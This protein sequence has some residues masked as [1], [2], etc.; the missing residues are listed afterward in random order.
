MPVAEAVT[1]GWLF[2]G[3]FFLLALAPLVFW[4]DLYESLSLPKRALI[5]TGA[6]V[7]AGLAAWPGRRWRLPQP[8]T[9]FLSLFLLWALVSLTWAVNPWLGWG[10]WWQWLACVL[11]GGCVLQLELTPQRLRG[12]LWAMAG[13]GAVVAV[14]GL[15]QAWFQWN[16]VPQAI[17]PAATLANRNMAAQVLVL[18]IP[19]AAVLVHLARGRG[20]FIAA[21][22]ALTLSLTY[23]GHTFTKSCWIALAVS[24]GAAL[25]LGYQCGWRPRL[26]SGN[27]QAL[28]VAVVI[29]S[30]AINVTKDGVRWRWP[31]IG[32]YL[33]GLAEEPDETVTE[34]DRLQA[35][36][37]RSVAVRT[38]FWRNTVE[39][40]REH[41][42]MGVGLNN[43]RVNYPA[44]TLKGTP[45]PT[46]Q[47]RS[48]E[49]AHNDVLQV[50]AELGT[51]G[52][53]LLVIVVGVFL[54]EALKGLRAVKEREEQVVLI[55][56]L[57]G[58][59]AIGVDSLFSFP[60]DREVPPLFAAVLAA[61]A[62]QRARLVKGEGRSASSSLK[63]G[64]PDEE[65]EERRR[66]DSA[67]APGLPAGSWQHGAMCC[68]GPDSK[69][70]K[71]RRVVAVVLF[72]GAVAMFV[73][74]Q[75]L[76]VADGYFKEQLAA[77]RKAD[78]AEVI[79]LGELVKQMEPS[80]MDAYRMT[81]RAH[82]RLGQVDEAWMDLRLALRYAP[83]DTQLLYYLA[84]CAQKRGQFG[85][86]AEALQRASEIVPQDA[87]YPHHLGLVYIA[88]QEG[89]KAVKALLQA[90]D[91]NPQDAAVYFNL[92]LA[93]E[94]VGQKEA[95]VA[96]YQKAL[97]LRPGWE[98]AKGRLD[99]VR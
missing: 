79:R 11:V 60:L 53:G 41:P 24:G 30:L 20:E 61:M 45:D 52:L 95:A 55:G 9:F 90:K 89:A 22:T 51:I 49:R 4:R 88:Q 76:W 21:A 66:C 44:A 93:Y 37:S 38:I 32:A 33:S 56:A 6:L 85:A 1:G 86:A 39:M 99:G 43:W 12:L 7:L 28:L 16:W 64:R 77:A 29:G 26:K 57:A 47:N 48:P 62:L 23:L 19:V 82:E 25:A 71:Y 17:A 54:R 67:D 14:I 35:K 73:W 27:F 97:E 31:E 74:Q 91:L 58:L 75:R 50:W 40:I 94:M 5:Q 69:V 78:W 96:S 42:V 2:R 80:R 34:A 59:A 65:R 84:I 63:L 83:D 15:G 46:L 10:T 68:D 72:A 8:F 92:G 18:V 3:L 98:E 36:A 70:S 87:L 81:G 13:S